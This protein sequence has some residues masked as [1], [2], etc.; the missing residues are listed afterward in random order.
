MLSELRTPKFP[1]TEEITRD[2]EAK[3]NVFL[4]AEWK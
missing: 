2:I 4:L 3:Q 1:V